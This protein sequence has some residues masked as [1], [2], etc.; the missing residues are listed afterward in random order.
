M[1]M[2]GYSR[3][4]S[5]YILCKSNLLPGLYIAAHGNSWCQIENFNKI[6]VVFY[7]Y[8]GVAHIFIRIGIPGYLAIYWAGYPLS[9]LRH[10]IYP[11]VQ[12]IAPTCLK[13]STTLGIARPYNLSGDNI[14]ERFGS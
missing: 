8:T 6:L 5:C 7:H 2:G 1:H 3:I 10:Y 12:P 13:V 4:P 14:F 11:L 9:G